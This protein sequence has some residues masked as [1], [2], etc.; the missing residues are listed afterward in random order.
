VKT[1]IRLCLGGCRNIRYL[2]KALELL[3]TVQDYEVS[4]TLL[5]AL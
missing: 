1:S 2:T 4:S 3:E 5:D